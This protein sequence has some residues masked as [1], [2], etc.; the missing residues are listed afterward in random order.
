MFG[1][2]NLFGVV[3]SPCVKSEQVYNMVRIDVWLLPR[4]LRSFAF[5]F[6]FCF[7]VF[8]GHHAVGSELFSKDG[9]CRL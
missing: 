3:T 4:S 9:N 8:E 6:S 1:A 2:L 5:S 7:V